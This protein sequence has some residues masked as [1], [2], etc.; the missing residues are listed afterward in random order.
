[1]VWYL[2]PEYREPKPP[3]WWPLGKMEIFYKQSFKL[4]CFI[5]L[6]YREKRPKRRLKKYLFLTS[7]ETYYKYD[8]K[9]KDIIKQ[10]FENKLK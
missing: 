8:H 1:M 6:K 10:V 4:Q 5:Y 7:E 9:A 2:T 3:E